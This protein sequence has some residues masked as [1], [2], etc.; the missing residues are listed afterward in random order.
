MSE[1]KTYSVSELSRLAGVSIRTLHHYD[2]IDLLK[3]YRNSQNGYRE[4][5]HS[6]LIILQQILIYRELDFSIRNIKD[7]LHTKE[8][9]LLN[10]L[11]AQRSLLVN[12]QDNLQKM[13][14]S[15]DTSVNSLTSKNHAAILYE[16]IPKEKAEQWEDL[17]AS[18]YGKGHLEDGLQKLST[19]DESDVRRIKELSRS[20]G[21]A[22]AKSLGSSVQSVEV[23]SIVVQQIEW[24]ENFLHL[25]S[26]EH[27]KVTYEVVVKFATSLVEVPA[28]GGLYEAFGVGTAKHL[29][30]AMMHYAEQNLKPS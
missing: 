28:F 30:E 8:S 14:D 5:R 6:D 24:L 25:T 23:Q 17:V 19:L 16:G 3:P 29:S 13:I 9:N 7:L 12:R 26:S 27:E 22:I 2:E 21:Q 18:R 4:Y 11:K 15:L 1:E 10:T 20:V